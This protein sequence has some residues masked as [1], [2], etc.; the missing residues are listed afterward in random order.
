MLHA[1]EMGAALYDYL[2]IYIQCKCN[3]DRRS[4]LRGPASGNGRRLECALVYPG[5]TE[6]TILPEELQALIADILQQQEA[7]VQGGGRACPA[8]PSRYSWIGHRY[9]SGAAGY[10]VVHMAS[11]VGIKIHGLDLGSLRG[12]VRW[13]LL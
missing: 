3:S 2:S 5:R 12:G 6:S 7:D 1:T 9:D 4:Q 8:G 11:W 10:S 13:I